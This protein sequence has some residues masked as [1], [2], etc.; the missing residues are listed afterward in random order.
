MI[1]WKILIEYDGKPFVGWQRQK[2]GL[3][4]QQCL[5]EALFQ[6][7]QEQVRVYA[8]G[9]TD[10]GVHA[11]GQVCHCDLKKITSAM[12]IQNAVNFYLKP[13]PIA[14][15]E[16]TEVTP[17][18]HARFSA[19][20]R[21]YCYRI[22]NQSPPLTLEKGR[23][24]HIRKP[25]DIPSMQEASSVLLGKHDFSTF[26]TARCQAK[27]PVKTLN[28]LHVET[29]KNIITIYATARSFLHSQ[30]RNMVG[31]LILV[32]LKRWT[33]NDLYYA[34]QARNRHAGPPTAPPYGLYFLGADYQTSES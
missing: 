2:N 8:A 16:I 9:R 30:V 6:F 10:A 32:G 26:R 7:S 31:A 22:I 18:F 12:T 29:S 15:L 20:Q 34:L 5:E 21:H 23:A 3:T 1:R 13:Y 28:Q 27:S 19:N 25:L 4:I 24:L 11:L 33:I 14:V 17:Y